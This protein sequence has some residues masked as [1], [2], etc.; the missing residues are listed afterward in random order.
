[1]KIS[2]RLKIAALIPM[3]T[4]LVIGTALFFSFRTLEEAQRKDRAAQ[5]IIFCMNELSNLVGEHIIYNEERPLVQFLAEHDQLTRFIDTVRFEDRKQK[6]LLE[7]IRR[8]MMM[9]KDSFLRL[10]SNHERHWSAEGNELVNEVE[11]RLAGR[12]LVWSRDVVAHAAAL[13]RR[14]MD[15]L[16]R[17]QRKISLLVFGL[18]AVAASVFSL[19]LLGMT[20]SI[21]VSLKRLRNGINAVATGDLD[22]RVTMPVRDEIGELS[23]AF[24]H[25]TGRLQDVTVSRDT[26]QREVEE[27][28]K[29]E[30]QL[31][32]QR[33]LFRVT[34]HSIGDAV[35][36]TDTEALVSYLNPVASDL[37]GW[38]LEEA[39]GLPVQTVLRT[40]NEVTR[41][42][43]DDIVKR[44]LVENRTVAMAN[45]TVLRRRDGTEIAIED[46]AAPI[47]DGAG[48]LLGVVIV[49]H[50]IT[51]KRRAQEA[52]RESAEKLRIIAD[53]TYDWEYWRSPE[54]RFIHVS[55]SCERITG[56]RAEAFMEDPELYLRIIHP[57]DRDRMARHW[58]ENELQRN[59][60]EMEFR[61][62]R[63]DGRERWIAHACLDV[64]DE[65]GKFLGRRASNRDITARKVAEEALRKSRMDLEKRVRERTAD[66]QERT[67]EMEDFTYI[68][69]H[70]L[71]E[72]L[73]KISTFGDLLILKAGDSLN[74]QSRDYLRRMQDAA[75]RM[76]TLLTSLLDYSRV[77]RR[78]ARI[79]KI[80]LGEPVEQSLSNL[81][82][83]IREKG[84]QVEIGELPVVEA[85]PGQMVQLFQNLIGNALKFQS[86][87][88]PPVVK[89]YAREKK[90]RG[91]GNETFYRVYV[92]DN[93]IGFDE[94]KYLSQIF[95]PFQRLHGRGEFEGV[96]IG[97]GICKKIVERHGGTLTA[98]STP[99]EG[100]TFIIT[101][102]ETQRTAD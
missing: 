95:E 91:P 22:H 25:M 88:K 38:P 37:T 100:S 46:S 59:L 16:N 69:S 49:F 9:M 6:Q 47:R 74:E 70:D 101:L 82:I 40:T 8:D 5:Q 3:L 87:D 26:L 85:D 14:V 83:R 61:I 48:N 27:R 62:I 63:R 50:D 17:T 44:V 71:R 53:F 96:G 75:V 102:P 56:Y 29:A 67:K 31:R 33:E 98:K 77:S 15:E 78:N 97:L 45:H 2:T 41:E 7:D 73:R 19:M 57:E 55:P 42:S 93:G 65:N 21:A 60:C 28:K 72:P 66:L 32:E 80:H 10:V 20:R 79:E 34:L 76:D 36:T 11:R 43:I 12:L 13:Q 18:I 86:G 64:L 94:S 52:L 35:M 99:G 54:N 89:I 58:R 23:Q 90:E 1:M 30:A 68:A 92:Q 4:A 81:E 24:D 51:E 84:A 39:R